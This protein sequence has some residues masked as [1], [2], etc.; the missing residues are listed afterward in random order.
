MTIT[1]SP[2][3]IEAVTCFLHLVKYANVQYE[4]IL[5]MRWKSDNVSCASQ[6]EL[7]THRIVSVCRQNRTSAVSVHPI[8]LPKK[9]HVSFHYMALLYVHLH[10]VNGILRNPQLK[11]DVHPV[12]CAIYYAGNTLSPFSIRQTVACSAPSLPSF[13]CESEKASLTAS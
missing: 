7:I 8:L 2:F 11:P 10:P 13:S 4:K 6:S 9:S 3:I 1:R 12:H 5:N